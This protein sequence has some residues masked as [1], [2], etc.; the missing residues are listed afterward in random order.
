MGGQNGSQGRGSGM[1][2]GWGEAGSLGKQ[3]GRWSLSCSGTGCDLGVR[4][5]GH[6]WRMALG[7]QLKGLPSRGMEDVG[8][9]K[10]GTPGGVPG[11]SKEGRL[12]GTWGCS[13]EV[14]MGLWRKTGPNLAWRLRGRTQTRAGTMDSKNEGS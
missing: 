14:R 4:A 2:E 5:R 7:P 11:W 1:R 12:S 10:C 6:R 3:E 13:R 9:N 8:G